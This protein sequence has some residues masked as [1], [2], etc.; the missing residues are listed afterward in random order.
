MLLKVKGESLE[1]NLDQFYTDIKYSK[2]FYSIINEYINLDN[3]DI[4]LEPSAGTRFIFL[5]NG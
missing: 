3:M 1:K 4:L 5:F 2:Y